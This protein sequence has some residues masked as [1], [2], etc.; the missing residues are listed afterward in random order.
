[1]PIKFVLKF[2]VA[3]LILLTTTTAIAV[4]TVRSEKVREP[5]SIKIQ[6]LG[7]D[8]VST[9]F[10]DVKMTE[11][12]T[13]ATEDAGSSFTVTI[14]ALRSI[15][16]G[17]SFAWDLPA[18][19]RLIAGDLTGSL[20]ALQAGEAQQIKIDLAGF[21]KQQK[22][23]LGLYLLSAIFAGLVFVSAYTI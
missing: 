13:A 17:L 18:G 12:N 11:S 8:Q 22:Q 9:E 2:V 21:S 4:L 5:A 14:S 7:A 15:P 3:P 23:F 1:M 10:F 20:Y 16:T 19:A 6:K